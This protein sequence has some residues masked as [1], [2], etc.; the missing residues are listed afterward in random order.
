MD[1]GLADAMGDR[2]SPE[3]NLEYSAPKDLGLRSLLPYEWNN[4]VHTLA[5]DDLAWEYFYS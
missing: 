1:I 4:Y 3:W 5:I 2:F